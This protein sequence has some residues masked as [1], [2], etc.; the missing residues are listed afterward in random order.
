[1]VTGVTL[2]IIRHGTTLLT[3]IHHTIGDGDIITITT[4]R[5]T[6]G[7]G[8]DITILVTQLMVVEAAL[9]TI[10][11]IL[12]PAADLKQLHLQGDR[13]VQVLLTE[14]AVLLV[15]DVYKWFSKEVV[16]LKVLP[17]LQEQPAP[18]EARLPAV[19]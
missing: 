16:E 7:I 2:G 4:I 1:M 18:E 8:P 3:I 11:D 17:E 6:I 5:H 19:A 10:T 14:A 12:H 13:A 9:P 15:A